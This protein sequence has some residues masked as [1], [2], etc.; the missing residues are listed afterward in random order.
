MGKPAPCLTSQW[1]KRVKEDPGAIAWQSLDRSH[2]YE[3]VENHIQQV[4]TRLHAQHIATGTPVLVHA[5][6]AWNGVIVTWA[7]WRLGAI[8]VPAGP[9]WNRERILGCQQQLSIRLYLTDDPNAE[10]SGQGLLIDEDPVPVAGPPLPTVT[11]PKGHRP[12]LAL[13]TTGST[14]IPKPAVWSESHLLAVARR[15]QSLL[16]LKQTDRQTFVYP[17]NTMGAWLDIL[18]AWTSGASLHPQDL[19]QTTLE[20]SLEWMSSQGITVW[21]SVPGLVRQWVDAG[22]TIPRD[23]ALRWIILGGDFIRSREVRFLQQNMPE[24]CRI[25]LGMGSTEMG[26]IFART[27]GKGDP[28]LRD[29]ISVGDPLPGIQATLSETHQG[30]GNLCL[31]NPARASTDWPP[32]PPPAQVQV[33]TGDRMLHDPEL[34]WVPMGRADGIVKIRGHRVHPAETENAL[35]R[36]PGVR[37]AAVIP[38]QLDGKETRLEAF[39]VVDGKWDSSRLAPLVSSLPSGAFPS[40]CHCLKAMPRLAHGKVDRKA[41][42]NLAGDAS[43]RMT[44]LTE[45]TS[46]IESIWKR[47]L[48]PRSGSFL[49]AGGDSLMALEMAHVLS[50]SLGQEVRPSWVSESPNPG[51]L[52][53]RISESSASSWILR[54]PSGSRP[55][56]VAIPALGGD[57]AGFL[58]LARHLHQDQ[59]LWIW[60]PESLKEDTTIE[61]IALQLLEDLKSAGGSPPAHVLGLSVGGRIAMEAVRQWV[62]NSRPGLVLIDTW[63]PDLD[64]HLESLRKPADLKWSE[65]GKLL[66]RKSILHWTILNALPA[67]ERMTYIMRRVQRRWS[68]IQTDSSMKPRGLLDQQTLSQARQIHQP[69]PFPHA[70]LLLRG[71]LQLSKQAEQAPWL[72]W[73]QCSSAKTWKQVTV[74]GFH[75]LLLHPPFVRDFSET[76]QPLLSIPSHSSSS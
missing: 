49:E 12:A 60:Q 66:G 53:Q 73:E 63:G 2:T 3:D 48:G 25:Y 13:F 32:T 35:L 62:G 30:V 1:W 75:H 26:S 5:R 15:R 64:D 67:G 52:A 61:A 16:N 55:P 31:V 44:G 20:E 14:G 42:A 11:K 33:V 27:I 40:A 59:P 21:H 68:G 8:A 50:R 36:I 70:T 41:L 51:W 43:H 74:T 71:S 38:V 56:W 29:P 34:G 72:G 58:Q 65:K 7:L 9:G 47:F 10:F 17:W 18:D 4:A 23:G 37:E 69:A 19:T 22:L 57:P 6:D 76:L 28:V 54:N 24:S 39:L 46:Q 45:G